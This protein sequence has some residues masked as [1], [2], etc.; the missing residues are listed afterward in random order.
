M[1]KPETTNRS[2][3]HNQGCIKPGTVQFAVSRPTVYRV[4]ERHRANTTT[5][6]NDLGIN[7]GGLM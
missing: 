3:S 5:A 6:P 2:H 4:L 7:S 1:H